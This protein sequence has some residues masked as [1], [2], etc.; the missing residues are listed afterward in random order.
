MRKMKGETRTPWKMDSH[1]R[2]AAKLEKAHAM[3][4]R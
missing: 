4:K 2:A 1:T 3:I